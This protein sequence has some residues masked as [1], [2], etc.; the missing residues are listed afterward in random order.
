LAYTLAARE[1]PFMPD[2]YIV[3]D[4]AVVFHERAAVH[5]SKSQA[6]GIAELLARPSVHPHMLNEATRAINLPA[7]VRA[8]VAR[9][10]YARHHIQLEE[11]RAYDQELA[12]KKALLQQSSLR[13]E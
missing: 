11:G 6:A 7:G 3:D 1:L 2:S 9:L 12:H 13:N 4:R 8:A 5:L 10:A